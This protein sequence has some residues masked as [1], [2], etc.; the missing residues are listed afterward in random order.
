MSSDSNIQKPIV[1]S[2]FSGC[3]G[4][5]LGFE[6]AGYEIGLA[7]DLRT[8]A[9]DSHNHNRGGKY[10]GFVRDISKI[11]LSD[12]DSDFGERFSPNGVIGGPPCQS[13]SRGNSAK[14]KDDPRTKLVRTFFNL[15]LSVHRNRGG[16]DFIVMENVPE[17]AT[18]DQG[19]LI[20]TEIERLEESGFQVNSH[21]YNSLDYQVPQKRRRL[22]LVAL[23]KT[24]ISNPWEL[25]SKSGHYLTVK[26][27]I[28][29][30]ERPV[31]FNEANKIDEFPVHPNHWCMTPKSKKFS[32]GSLLLSRTNGRS[33]K[34]LTWEEPSFTVS[35]GHR[36]VHVHPDGNRR[37]SVFE[38]M[39]LQG[40][41][42]TFILK[43]NLSEQI[44]QV[45]EAVPP[46]L[47]EAIANSIHASVYSEYSLSKAASADA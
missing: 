25:P 37:L 31:Y 15:A 2:L 9:I 34:T 36:E 10:S 5:D 27:A 33:F 29:G 47:A 35:Y 23:N 44:S 6:H 14:K 45:S 8:A 19:R 41:P 16:L 1:L 3:G 17:I 39:K 12:L 26:D 28:S 38:A 13:F 20:R 24:R 46:P 42:E 7:Y 18:A 22:I 32:D 40:F 30:L 21:V 4:L 43:G 11:S